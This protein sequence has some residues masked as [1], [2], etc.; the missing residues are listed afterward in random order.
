MNLLDNDIKFIPGVGEARAKLL[1]KE[2]GVHTM[3]DMLYHFPFRYID[4]SKVYPI[5]SLNE[6]NTSSGYIQ[7]RGKITGKSF[8]G[9]GRRRR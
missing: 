3:R 4:R 8:F 2:I 5:G 6:A 1:A 7:I 9:E